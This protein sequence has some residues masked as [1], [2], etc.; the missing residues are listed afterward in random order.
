MI[1]LADAVKRAGYSVCYAPSFSAAEISGEGNWERL[2]RDCKHIV[3][4]TGFICVDIVLRHPDGERTDYSIGMA[5]IQVS[6]LPWLAPRRK[7][8]SIGVSGYVGVKPRMSQIRGLRWLA[9]VGKAGYYKYIGMF[10]TALA[11]AHARD[12]FI[13]SH[14]LK[15]CRL[16]IPV[17]KEAT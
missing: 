14:H 15:Q 17:P 4:R 13:R 8:M 11:A 5:G 1:A 10:D 12:E 16:C 2:V 7:V 9:E 3:K 6:P